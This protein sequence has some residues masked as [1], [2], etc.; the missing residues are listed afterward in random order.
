MRAM[1]WCQIPASRQRDRLQTQTAALIEAQFLSWSRTTST[2]GRPEWLSAVCSRAA[3]HAGTQPCTARCS[4]Q[5]GSRWTRPGV[6]GPSGDVHAQGVPSAPLARGDGSW[7]ARRGRRSPGRGEPPAQQR[8]LKTNVG[9]DRSRSAWA[10]PIAGQAVSSQWVRG[11]WPGGAGSRGWESRDRLV[12]ARPV[13]GAMV[14]RRRRSVTITS[15]ESLFSRQAQDIEG[16]DEV[17]GVVRGED[18]TL[19]R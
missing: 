14:E 3:T 12:S 5:P 17:V 7:S 11:R 4:A 16:V 18:H 19:H 15:T 6:P 1:S 8:R 13:V 10:R 2:R 9:T